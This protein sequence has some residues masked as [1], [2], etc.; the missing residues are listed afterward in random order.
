[1]AQGGVTLGP[2]QDE[3]GANFCYLGIDSKLPLLQLTAT[4]RFQNMGAQ[5]LVTETS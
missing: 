3:L 4:K 2:E 1:V 5:S